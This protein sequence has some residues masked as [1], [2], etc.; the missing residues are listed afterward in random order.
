MA[1]RATRKTAA[2]AG[3]AVA[4]SLQNLL[5]GMGGY[6]DKTV[7]TQFGHVPMDQAQLQIAYRNDWIARKVIDIPAQDAT[8]EW[9]AWQADKEDITKL[10]ELERDLRIQ[11]KTRTV[12]QKARLYGGGALVMGVAQGNP[13]QELVVDKI[14]AGSLK[15]VHAVSRYELSAGPINRDLMSP[16]YGEPEYYQRN[17]IGSGV[18]VKFHPSRVVRFVGLE[19][20]DSN[21]SDGWGDPVLQIV[22]QAIKAAG[23]VSQGV[24]HL[25]EEAKV[26]VIKI[27]SLTSQIMNPDYEARMRR[28]FGLAS[29]AKSIYKMLLLDKEEE[30]D[31]IEQ[32]FS[33]MPDLVKMYLLL[34]S[35]AA[36]IPAT[37]ML[38]QSPV[39]M[40]ST[41]DS[42]TRNYYDRIANEQNTDIG[43]V[44]D[45]LDEVLIRS[46]LGDRPE[47]L[48]YIWNP[49]WQLDEK[50]RAA[51]NY[52]KA[53]TFK[54]DVDAGLVD[55]AV[56]KDAR[57][58]QLIEDGV[59]PGIEMSIEEFGE[60]YEE[61]EPPQPI[62]IPPGSGVDP[63]A[64]PLIPPKTAEQTAEETADRIK[65]TD[66]RRRKRLKDA[67]PRTLYVHRKLLNWQAVASHFTDQGF[68]VTVGRE[69]HVTL[70]HSRLP[71]DWM[72]AG[73]SWGH[74]EKGTLSVVPGGVRLVE[75]L[76]DAL[77]LMFVSSH[78]SWRWC[79]I[80][81]RT[82]AEWTWPDYQPHVTITYQAGDVDLTTI[83]PYTGPL[84]FGPEIFEE[85][86]ENYQ[87]TLV[88]DGKAARFWS[89][90]PKKNVDAAS[91]SKM[92]ADAV[93]ATPPPAINVTVPITMPGKAKTLTKINKV[94]ARGRILE[95]E[96]SDVEDNS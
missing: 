8:R 13:D 77:V 37:R 78:L 28:R 96:R 60:P 16:Y 80:K 79:E 94:D 71:V 56:L 25:V 14:K 85:I 19:Y 10:E 73:E 68:A 48:H 95:I 47:E 30:W 18:Q 26:D 91:I 49:L 72:K 1:K 5:S 41:G 82:G 52:Q 84:E 40:N 62:L 2:P 39:G 50:D 45:R 32:N 21:T 38:G 33:T 90:L 69:M 27:P 89:R 24:A 17:A 9:R 86:N 22:Q 4:D 64:P 54:I 74:D 67:T 23:S 70:A 51:V 12:M 42:D 83:E 3:M 46:A 7:F 92:V 44:L 81:E 93:A 15:F 55:P 36:D 63:N 6:G 75:K 58:N 29:D 61:P 20:P 11:R 87:E 66:V 34:A 43:P 76:G 59:Y 88:E 35:G 31:R 53:Q 65:T 57:E